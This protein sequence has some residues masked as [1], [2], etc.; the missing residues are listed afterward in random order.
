[1][2][3]QIIRFQAHRRRQALPQAWTGVRPP[4]HAPGQRLEQQIGRI[5]DLLDELEGLTR[6]ARHVPPG[7]LAKARVTMD[8]ARRLV[9]GLELEEEGDPQPEVD[10]EVLERMYREIKPAP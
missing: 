5:A 2:S 6:T 8:K 3:G 10:G 9:A 7:V 4:G 1:M